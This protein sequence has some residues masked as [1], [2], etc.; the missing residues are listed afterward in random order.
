[1]PP[2]RWDIM[3]LS[4][5][6]DESHDSAK[7]RVFAVSGV[8]GTDSEW[9]TVVRP[10]NEYTKGEI[11]HAADWERDGRKDDIKA[12]TQILARSCVCAFTA[13]LDL[14]SFRKYLG[15]G[16]DEIGYFKCMTDILSIMMNEADKWNS[17]HPN[18]LVNLEFTFDHRK[19]TAGNAGTLYQLLANLPEWD[20]ASIFSSKI[21]FDTRTNTKIQI[22]DLVAREAM[23]ELDRKITGQPPQRRRSCE[24]LLETKRFTFV[25]RGEEFCRDWK[26][27]RD[28]LTRNEGPTREEF[29]EWLEQTGRVQ[30]GIYPDNPGTR[31]Q[32]MIWFES[33]PGLPPMFKGKTQ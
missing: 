15:Q 20:D 8:F 10:W 21:S 11:F 2:I 5:F 27:T 19:Q 7:E 28:S 33:K 13:A 29:K 6:G 18:E 22:A 32:Y 23:K 16:M 3:I 1:M 14:T 25:E 31:L 26:A 9:D 12:L 30:N 24:A 4:V 17:L